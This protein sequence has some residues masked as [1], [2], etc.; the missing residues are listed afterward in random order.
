MIFDSV[1]VGG[2]RPPP[3]PPV[4]EDPLTAASSNKNSRNGLQH[5]SMSAS[6]TSEAGNAATNS[7]ISHN[8]HTVNTRNPKSRFSNSRQSLW[9]PPENNV[10]GKGTSSHLGPDAV[11]GDSGRHE[12]HGKVREK[13]F[14]VSRSI[15][16]S[17]LGQSSA[18]PGVFDSLHQSAGGGDVLSSI[19]VHSLDSSTFMSD[20]R[21]QGAQSQSRGQGQSQSWSQG[22]SQSPV[23]QD[24]FSHGNS[25]DNGVFGSVNTLEGG[26]MGSNHGTNNQF[27]QGT[28]NNVHY[29][30]TTA[31]DLGFLDF[32]TT[33]YEQGTVGHGG[34][35]HISVHQVNQGSREQ[36]SH[37]PLEQLTLE[38][39]PNASRGIPVTT[40][41][42]FPVGHLRHNVGPNFSPS[43][44]TTTLMSNGQFADHGNVV[45]NTRELPRPGPEVASRGTFFKQ[46]QALHD[47]HLPAR[48]PASPSERF[49]SL[50]HA[51]E[52]AEVHKSI[53]EVTTSPR[54]L[55]VGVDMSHGRKLYEATESSHAGSSN[56]SDQVFES[57][58]KFSA[59]CSY[60]Y[61]YNALNIE[62]VKF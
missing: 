27:D 62:I 58:S 5:F 1:S 57:M 40:P 31:S 29:D 16:L 11:V 32:T 3:P 35:H 12:M 43:A 25:V 53:N 17:N 39:G 41:S 23:G 34:F 20:L 30:V 42:S 38:N 47:S 24:V 19:G 15:D 4:L 46:E 26:H 49:N 6:G 13:V 21:G 56:K 22:Q 59:F 7:V 51:H 48:G 60:Y 44:T 8:E 52:T 10:H 18:G 36:K 50:A 33:T 55:P 28:V 2:R 61:V 45:S 54:Q 9:N 37:A 14:H